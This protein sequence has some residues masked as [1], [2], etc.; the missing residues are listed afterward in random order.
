MNTLN[1]LPTQFPSGHDRPHPPS[2]GAAHRPRPLQRLARAS[3]VAL[4]E[5]N[6]RVAAY[7]QLVRPLAHHYAAHTGL[8]ADD[9]VQVGL[10]GLIRAAERFSEL[11]GT[12]F[13]SFAR[14]H[15]R[16]AIL[17]YLRDA[18]HPVRLP[19]RQEELRLRLR[20]L[21]RE[22]VGCQD[23]DVVDALCCRRLG[24]SPAGLQQLRQWDQLRRPC[25]LDLEDWEAIACSDDDPAQE[26]AWEADRACRLLQQLEPRCR[27][28]VSQVV[29]QGCSYRQVAQAMAVS[30]MTVQRLLRRGLESLRHQL[31]QGR[32]ITTGKPEQD[33][34]GDRAPSAVRGC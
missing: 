29:L 32:V 18:A 28:V 24:I 2:T 4:D 19:R 30:P 9:L 26:R 7:Q 31:A 5:R 16:G 22:L 12:P 13:P 6:R 25:G 3:N 23:P 27:Q 21:D 34:E 33:P 20:Q 15:I 14:P 8:C 10:M 1:A 17:H 11:Q